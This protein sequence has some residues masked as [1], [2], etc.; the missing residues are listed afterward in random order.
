MRKQNGSEEKPH[1]CQPTCPPRGIT[2]TPPEPPTPPPLRTQC[3]APARMPS[4]PQQ[5]RLSVSLGVPPPFLCSLKELLVHTPSLSV[6]FPTWF[7]LPPNS[8]DHGQV[9]QVAKSNVQ[10]SVF[11]ALDPGTHSH[12]QKPFPLLTLGRHWVLSAQ[13][14]AFSVSL[15]MGGPSFLSPPLLS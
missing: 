6:P 9:H 8:N 14:V 4:L 7:P 12:L 2:C 5:Q 15:L 1:T 10:F 13:R 11:I 3:P